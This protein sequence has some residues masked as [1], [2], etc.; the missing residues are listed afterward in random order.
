MDSTPSRWA[1]VA[2]TL[3]AALCLL[4]LLYFGA[5]GLIFVALAQAGVPEAALE[6]AFAP[7]IALCEN[8]DLYE[9]WIDWQIDWLVPS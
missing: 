8:W 9:R 1:L 5:G 7:L 3:A 6:I 4:G 2:V